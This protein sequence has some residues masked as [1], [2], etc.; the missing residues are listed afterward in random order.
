MDF[1]GIKC[2]FEMSEYFVTQCLS[3]SLLNDV[4]DWEGKTEPVV[5]ACEAD[6][7]GALTMQIMK[8]ISGLPTALLDLRFYDEK[9]KAF[10]FVNC[11]ASAPYF[12]A[13]NSD[14]KK[15]LSCVSLCPAIKKYKGGGAHVNL[16]YKEGEFTAARLF[17][18]EEKLYQKQIL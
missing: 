7:D 8:L 1:I 16:D 9:N 4:C 10:I 14:C 15:N 5:A 13:R 17:R 2:H 12:A 18:R 11:G 6:S 3:I